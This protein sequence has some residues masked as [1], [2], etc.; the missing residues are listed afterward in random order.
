MRL[1]IFQLCIL[2]FVTACGDAN[3]FAELSNTPPIIQTISN[4]EVNEGETVTLQVDAVDKESSQLTYLWKQESGLAVD[5]ESN[6]KSELIFVAPNVALVDV[7]SSLVF[8]VEV[9]DTN[10]AKSTAKVTVNVL[11]LALPPLIESVNYS[12]DLF[13]KQ[14]ATFVCIVTD[15]DGEIADVSLSQIEG[16]EVTFISKNNCSFIIKVPYVNA[17]EEITLQLAAKDN[18]DLETE[19]IYKI[20]LSPTQ[21]LNDTGVTTCIDYALENSG[22]DSNGLDCSLENDGEGDPIPYG[23]DAHYGRDVKKQRHLESAQITSKSINE[24]NKTNKAQANNIETFNGFSY[25]KIA[26]DGS[27]LTDDAASWSCI[28]DNVTGLLWEIKTIDGTLH[29]RDY[30]YTWYEPD[31]GK[32]SG[33]AGVEDGGECVSDFCDTHHYV[34]EVNQEGYCGVNNWR[35]PTPI[36]LFSISDL[37]KENPAMDTNYFLNNLGRSLYWSSIPVVPTEYFYGFS[38]VYNS[39]YGIIGIMPHSSDNSIRLVSNE[40]N[41]KD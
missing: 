32:N 23:Q 13:S 21:R 3:K 28:K 8:A 16:S 14:T 5:L 2:F 9:I 31:D 17:V 34:I 25:T 40:Q 38:K 37:S 1:I 6:N 41:L 20:M 4:Q 12:S 30:T 35:L 10:G 18:D 33:F 39:N 24:S 29:D 11:A 19:I 27:V 22:K 15:S 7:D 36:E 26:A